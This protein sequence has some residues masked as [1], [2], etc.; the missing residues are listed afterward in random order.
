MNPSPLSDPWVVTYD[1]GKYDH[2]LIET[3]EY[4]TVQS[5]VQACQVAHDKPLKIMRRSQCR[6]W[7]EMW[8]TIEVCDSIRFV[9]PSEEF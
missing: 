6:L 5:Y 8:R 3:Q 1:M 9:G 2:I 4:Q 7:I